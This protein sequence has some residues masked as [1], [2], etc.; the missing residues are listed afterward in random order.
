M[1]DTEDIS[2]AAGACHFLTA[3]GPLLHVG[4]SGGSGEFGFVTGGGADA[5]ELGEGAG[6]I[7][8]LIGRECSNGT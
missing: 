7:D 8:S 1:S 4:G 6:S 3:R 5:A 2:K